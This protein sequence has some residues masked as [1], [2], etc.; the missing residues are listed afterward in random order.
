[1]P[2]AYVPMV[3]DQGED[4]SAQIVWTD[5]Y[6]EPQVITAPARMDVKNA[7]GQTQFTLTT[8]EEDLPPGE[9]P[10]IGISG[11]LGLIQ[12]HI[13]RTVTA[14]LQPGE[15]VYD[16]FISVDD[17]DAYAGD[18]VQRILYGPVTVNKRVTQL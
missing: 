15:Y 10:Q 12:L 16:L 7:G 9:I 14:A 18:Q 4:Y 17:G 3:I 2:A 8:P 5:E 13:E 1:M 6:D 11:D